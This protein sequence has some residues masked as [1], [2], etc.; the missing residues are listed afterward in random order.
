MAYSASFISLNNEPQE[1]ALSQKNLRKLTL[2]IKSNLA[3]MQPGVTQC[4]YATK[5][6][7]ESF[8]GVA[9]LV[10]DDS[11]QE[12]GLMQTGIR[13]GMPLQPSVFLSTE[14]EAK[15]FEGL[16]EGGKK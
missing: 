13:N 16:K 14:A 9:L 11:D 6:N 4:C 12:F 3:A 15:H 8:A 7:G 5:V 10:S 2:W 1:P